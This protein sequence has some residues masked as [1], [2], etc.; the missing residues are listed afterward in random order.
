VFKGAK[1]Q[2]IS[3]EVHDRLMQRLQERIAQKKPSG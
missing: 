3:A 2:D 1:R